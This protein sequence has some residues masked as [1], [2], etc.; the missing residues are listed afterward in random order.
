M[1]NDMTSPLG[2][3][4]AGSDEA[5]HAKILDIQRRA[6]LV[7]QKS[8]MRLC[9]QVDLSTA[10]SLRGGTGSIELRHHK[11]EEYIAVSCPWSLPGH[12]TVS[13][14][15]RFAPEQPSGVIMPPDIVLERILNFKICNSDYLD[16]PFWV[17][18]LCINQD[19]SDE[20]AMAVHSMDLVYQYS[21]KKVVT[22]GHE[23]ILGCSLGLLF[24]EVT[25]VAQL[26]ML[27]KLLDSK[28]A[29]N[30]GNAPKLL[31]SVD[32]AISVLELI[33]AIIQDSWW[34][35]AWIFQ[36]E[37]LA[38][39]HM[40]LLLP[41]TL[42]RTGLFENEDGVDLFGKTAGE[43]EVRPLNFRTEVTVFCLA[44]SR[45]A[46]KS[47]QERCFRILTYAR[48]YTF[49][50]R[51]KYSAGPSSVVH[52]MSPAIFEDIS[53]RGITVPSDILAIAANCCRYTSRLDAQILN[54]ANE[55]LSMAIL[56]LFVMN[57]EIFRQDVQPETITQQNVLECLR[58]AKLRV[59]P[60]LQ[61][62]ELIF[63][64]MSRLPTVTMSDMGLTV[65]GALSRLDKRIK[66][67]ISTTDEEFY[68]K[69]N[70]DTQT[71]T[72]SEGEQRLLVALE[73][74]LKSIYQ[75]GG[76]A[77]HSKLREFLNDKR[78]SQAPQ[79]W[80]QQHIQVMM[81]KAVCRAI[82]ERR[83]LWLSRLHVPKKWT[84]WLGIFIPDD[85]L[86]ESAA[87]SFAFTAMQTDHEFKDR[88]AK[89]ARKN[90][91]VTSLQVRFNPGPQQI[92]PR[93]WMNGLSFFNNKDHPSDLTIPWPRWM[94]N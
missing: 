30:N 74:H 28:F 14:R 29:E 18:K 93:K 54:T 5:L 75:E 50:Y 36:E 3:I 67:K 48:R 83:P 6:Q 22:G 61:A 47:S 17:D 49:L 85:P 12:D 89:L 35:R 34:H 8:A 87:I 92:L 44:L 2:E 31:V 1:K 21:G 25:T 13:G 45:H 65:R 78:A 15:Y 81:A 57:G 66:V 52:A 73:G 16:T 91:R 72:L 37:F 41:C 51:S 10:T 94:S 86:N 4:S 38:S 33:E 63:I 27:R 9:V 26:T 56:T 60:P 62:A 42:D 84:P 23:Q 7:Q 71:N 53:T 46:D 58:T 24:V 70:D 19:A 82:A 55:S 76:R 77:L 40:I 39:R 88:G 68:W 90:T 79:F 32:E 80:S 64:K 43:I 69:S 11:S 59:I 20:K